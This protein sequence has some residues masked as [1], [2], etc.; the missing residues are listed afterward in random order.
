MKISRGRFFFWLGMGILILYC[1]PWT[2]KLLAPLSLAFYE[3]SLWVQ[4]KTGIPFL[5]T[6]YAFGALAIL[7]G[8]WGL[9][10]GWKKYPQ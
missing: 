3:S 9:W 2:W 1:L 7:L 6:V 5:V 4:A 10:H 8:A